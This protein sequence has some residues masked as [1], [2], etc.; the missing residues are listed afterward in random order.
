VSLKTFVYGNLSYFEI[1]L[2]FFDSNGYGGQIVVKR[3]IVTETYFKC[4]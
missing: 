3:V 1:L 2:L 4:V